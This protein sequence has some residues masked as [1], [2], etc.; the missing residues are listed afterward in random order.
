MTKMQSVKL[1]GTDDEY[2]KVLK[3]LAK[4]RQALNSLFKAELGHECDISDMEMIGDALHSQLLLTRTAVRVL[5]GKKLE[6]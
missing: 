5:M 3:L 1:S 6:D 4:N 2:E